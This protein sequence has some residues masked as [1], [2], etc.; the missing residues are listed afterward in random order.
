MKRLTLIDR[1]MNE[2]SYGNKVWNQLAFHIITVWWEL[3]L[4]NRYAKNVDFTPLLLSA[5]PHLV[6]KCS[7]NSQ[8]FV[9]QHTPTSQSRILITHESFAWIAHHVHVT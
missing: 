4:A 7:F 6:C 1:S 5:F 9:F 8:L 3:L 2:I